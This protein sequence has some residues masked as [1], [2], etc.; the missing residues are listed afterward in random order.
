MSRGWSKKCP[1]CGGRMNAKVRGVCNRCRAGYEDRA[2]R[3]R[4]R[5]SRFDIGVR[6]HCDAAEIERAEQGRSW[7]DED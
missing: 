6:S 5:P 2:D 4:R 3:D 1:E 7:F